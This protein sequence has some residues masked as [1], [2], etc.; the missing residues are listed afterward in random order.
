L[1]LGT[2][3]PLPP[4][5]HHSKGNQTGFCPGLVRFFNIYYKSKALI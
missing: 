4:E 2:S 5:F 3:P 1:S